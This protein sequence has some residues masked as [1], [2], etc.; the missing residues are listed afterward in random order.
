MAASAARRSGGAPATTMTRG[1]P[2]RRAEVLCPS[3][4]AEGQR[5]ARTG[6][7]PSNARLAASHHRHSSA[8]Q[9]VSLAPCRTTPTRTGGGL[10][11]RHAAQATVGHDG[12]VPPERHASATVRYFGDVADRE[13]CMRFGSECAGERCGHSRS[14][15]L[16]SRAGVTLHADGELP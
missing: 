8:A 11:G 14:P 1:S 13:G 15:L 3:A 9:A 6:A 7:G 5:G 16:S 10:P 12:W 4:W 2:A